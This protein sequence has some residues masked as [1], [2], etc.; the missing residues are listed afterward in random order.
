MAKKV[1]ALT[2]SQSKVV[3]NPPLLFM[4]QLGLPDLTRAKEQ[5]G[6]LP[7]VPLEQGLKKSIEYTVAQKGLLRP[8]FGK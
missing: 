8:G 5:L 4:T 6:W 3:F 7:L 2:N 1:I